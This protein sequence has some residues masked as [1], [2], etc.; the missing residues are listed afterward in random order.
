MFRYVQIKGDSPRIIP[1]FWFQTFGCLITSKCIDELEGLWQPGD[2]EEV[3]RVED[4][5]DPVMTTSFA[6]SFDLLY[7]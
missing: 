5:K 1:S 7:G 2:M 3:E 4:V 6:Q